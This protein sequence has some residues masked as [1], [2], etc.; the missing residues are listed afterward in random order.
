MVRWIG[1]I[2]RCGRAAGVVETDKRGKEVFY[3]LKC[4]CVRSFL[5][6]VE[7]KRRTGAC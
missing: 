6:C 2:E 5:R 7:A 1:L 3:R 4:S